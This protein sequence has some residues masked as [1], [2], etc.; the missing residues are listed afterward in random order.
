MASIDVTLSGSGITLNPTS[1]EID[2]REMVTWNVIGATGWELTI[3]VP[4]TVIVDSALPVN[5]PVTGNP[6]RRRLDTLPHTQ[7]SAGSN[8]LPTS[9]T[10]TLRNPNPLTGPAVHTVSSP[11]VIE[12]GVEPI[13][14]GPHEPSN[15][16]PRGD[17]GIQDLSRE[18]QR[19]A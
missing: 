3:V 5:S 6:V 1:T 4:A 16:F 7:R 8:K 17:A 18:E 15:V 12:R 11:L 9:Y 10:I 19:L 2:A 13:G 14:K